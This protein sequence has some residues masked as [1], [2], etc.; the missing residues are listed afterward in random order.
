MPAMN[1]L[2]LPGICKDTFVFHKALIV[3]FI[4]ARIKVILFLS[5][6]LVGFWS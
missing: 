6:Q 5:S 4:A 1:K 2:L 3:L